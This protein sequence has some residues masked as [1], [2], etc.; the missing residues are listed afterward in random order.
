MIVALDGVT[1]PR[2]RGAV[3]HS[4]AAFGAHGVL[5]P[6]RRGAGVFMAGLDAAGETPVRDLPLATARS[7]W[8]SA[9]RAVACPASSPRP[10]TSW[11][12]SP[13][14]PA[15][16][17]ST[18]RGRRH[19]PLRGSDPLPPHGLRL[20]APGPVSSAVIGTPRAAATAACQTGFAMTTNSFSLRV[21]NRRNPRIPP[22]PSSR[23]KMGMQTIRHRSS[24]GLRRC[25]AAEAVMFAL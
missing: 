8:S 21:T 6:S 15:P 9:R 13:S 25:R 20:A 4:A 24:S 7:P 17:P 12:A 5:V 1:D 16:N 2:N 3:A 14:P 22:S 10:A 23:E 18:P 19:R 11:S